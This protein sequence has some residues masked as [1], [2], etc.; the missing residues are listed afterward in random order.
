MVKC[1]T[2]PAVTMNTLTA[3]GNGFKK[4][5]L[6]DCVEIQAGKL[7]GIF[8][9]SQFGPGGRSLCITMPSKAVG[10]VARIVSPIEFES[11]S[12]LSQCHAW[13]RS[14]RISSLNKTLGQLIDSGDLK[15]CDKKCNCTLCQK[16]ND[17][18]SKKRRTSLNNRKD[19]VADEQTIHSK[20]SKVEN[21]LSLLGTDSKDSYP[22]NN[23][24]HLTCDY[25]NARPLDIVLVKEIEE[26][27][28]T[29]RLQF[30][31]LTSLLDSN[32][33]ENSFSR[34]SN[35]IG[36]GLECFPIA[37]KRNRNL[38][39]K[40]HVPDTSHSYVHATKGRSPMA[41]KADVRLS[42]SVSTNGETL[43]SE[44]SLPLL[45]PLNGHANGTNNG[46]YKDSDSDSGIS[47]IS[48]LSNRAL[49]NQPKLESRCLSAPN[50]QSSS[51][52]PSSTALSTT[53][54]DPAP[55]KLSSSNIDVS[56]SAIPPNNELYTMS[57]TPSTSR[58]PHESNSSKLGISSTSP[59]SSMPDYTTMVREAIASISMATLSDMGH[60]STPLEIAE[61]SSQLMIILYIL[62]KYKPYE[63]IN[64]IYTKVSTA[65]SLLER[66][67]IVNKLKTDNQHED[68]SD[69]EED[70]LR[71]RPEQSPSLKHSLLSKINNGNSSS[72]KKAAK[73][74]A[75]SSS[76]KEETSSILS[77]T[78]SSP[79]GDLREKI[80]AKKALA[81]IMLVSSKTTNDT[82]KTPIT[83]KK[84]E[85]V[86]TVIGTKTSGSK[87]LDIN[88]K[89]PTENL[90]KIKKTKDGSKKSLSN[91][92]AT[93]ENQKSKLNKIKKV[94]KK[95]EST[96]G[97]KQKSPGDKNSKG[98]PAV[99]QY[100][101]KRLSPELAAICGKKKL[102]RHDVVSR[103]WRYIKKKKLQDPDQRTTILCD[104]KLKALT[105]KPRIGQTDM[106]LCIGSH[107][108]LIH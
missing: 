65:L 29:T 48:N 61:N 102:S 100:Q 58:T 85:M 78:A 86:K 41:S 39:E 2:S 74:V 54:T 108:T 43:T 34:L 18:M 25:E 90:L 87:S 6:Q 89:S 14:L 97:L 81:N 51:T 1:V 59:T 98:P 15:I 63:D 72:K 37:A 4:N 71:S 67:G 46:P 35:G 30:P 9:A 73:N 36:R 107:L 12:D 40:K 13:K 103:M 94:K 26:D 33:P 106:L 27:L 11:M 104:D 88:S 62:R 28:S 19:G 53:P 101:L 44:P 42:P 24:L 45:T 23:R 68:D 83:L 80:N 8:D 32:I 49:Q 31:P 64:I 91:L 93:K 10:S 96:E 95:V 3:T 7:T 66:M 76:S 70:H 69:M 56:I 21:G 17:Y 20:S 50:D 16:S 75:K 55:S 22:S 105:Q 52:L 47:N 77:D 38:S 84:K 92:A 60:N 99:R 57:P 82:P 79:I 5:M